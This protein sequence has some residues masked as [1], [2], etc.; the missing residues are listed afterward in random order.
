MTTDTREPGASLL[1]PHKWK[2]GEHMA[3][4]GRT[5][6]GKSMLLARLIEARR[7]RIII[8]TKPDDVIY[9]GAR[10]VA[11]LRG[12]ERDR[13]AN[14][15]VLDP[16]YDEHG[17]E[18]YSTL[19]W[20]YRTGGWSIAI[21]ECYYVTKLGRDMELELEKLMTQGRSLKL[22]MV[23]GMQR[24]SRVPRFCLSEATHVLCFSMEGRDVKIIE[25]AH[26]PKIA[27][28]VE[29]LGRFEFAWYNVPARS[30]WRG[31]LNI[32]T[33]RLEATHG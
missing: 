13:D 14:A 27:A 22:T 1:L 16:A 7:Y 25:E 29:S 24:P 28:A 21:D 30:I 12:L 6:S 9:R 3:I 5:G 23:C 2:Q 4:V 31:R 19:E 26:G 18:I 11:T 32:K 10:E 15:F 17:P 8:R 20:A 33:G